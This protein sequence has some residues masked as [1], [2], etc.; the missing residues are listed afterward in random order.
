MAKR[1]IILGLSVAAVM[2]STGLAPAAGLLVTTPAEGQTAASADQG[3]V[4]ARAT[5]KAVEP[6][7]ASSVIP[8]EQSGPEFRLAGEDDTARFTFSLSAAAASAGGTL[9]LAYRNA[10]SVLPDT[11]ILDVV[12]NGTAIGTVPIASPN[13]F[14][15]EKLALAAQYLKEGRNEVLVRARQS[16][17][18]D[19]SLDATYELWTELDPATSGFAATRTSGFADV[20]DLMSVGRDKARKTDIR[21]I[22]PPGFGADMLNEAA[23]V[24]QTLSLYLNRDDVVV[25][26]GDA[27]GEGPGIDLIVA[28]DRTH[29]M[30]GE[31]GAAI[32]AAPYGLSVRNGKSPGRALLVLKASSQAE[33]TRQLLDAI[34]GPL[35]AGLQSGIFAA[36]SGTILAEA[37]TT[38]SLAQ[39]G[40]KTEMF[41]GRLSRTDFNLVMPADFYPAEYATVDLSLNAATS[42]GLKRT[43]QL[44]VRVNDR[45]VK[46]YPFR[47][48]DGE[49]F[50]GKQIELPL[51]AF[52]PGNN[53]VEILAEVPVATDDACAPAAR[54]EG[55]PRF[56]LLDTTEITV[57]AL[58]RIGRLPDLAAFAGKA[59]P[60][61]DGQA[62]DVF[63]ERPDTQSVGA[64]LTVLSRLA[65]TARNPL[66]ATIKLSAADA[67]SGRN[68]LVLAADN[69][70]AELG[71]AGKNG[72]PVGGD[73]TA[74]LAVDPLKTAGIGNLTI[75]PQM[76]S[77]AAAGNDPE[78]LLRA[79][80][81]STAGNTTDI[82]VTTQVRRWFLSAGERF[83]L[84]LNVGGDYAVPVNVSNGQALLGVTQMP[85]PDGRATWTVIRASSP[86]D[87]ALGARRLVEAPVWG[88]LSGGSAE[89]V[90]SDM[91]LVSTAARSV[92]IAGFNDHSLGNIRRLAAAWFSENFQFYVLVVI[93]LMGIFAVWLGFAVPRKGVRTQ[94]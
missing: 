21:L 54:Q 64:A 89:I 78:A 87:L 20:A 90:S 48:T 85:S 5:F 75:A 36:N 35:N 52:R 84:W 22:L 72:F 68:A 62:F 53:K 46:S 11:S 43:A 37:S 28:T 50:D 31:G 77:D 94:K 4:P 41:T 47:N 42:P 32:A 63:V 15:T 76:A 24:L 60:Y 13:G 44:L 86:R 66:N 81:N 34:K 23:P 12:V 57:P 82:S 8:F 45:V 26:V 55:K 25:S 67:A 69:S 79:F 83:G 3:L 33:V 1:R 27:P 70:F 56:L 88:A 92:Y 14:R 2:A 19:C 16:H 74:A 38:Y 17:R 59:Y 73:A 30:T 58:A 29:G 61:A 40:Y 9:D 91:S 7:E 71:H 49:Q 51:R 65:L 10:V 93:A 80:Q 39:T 18:V 6:K